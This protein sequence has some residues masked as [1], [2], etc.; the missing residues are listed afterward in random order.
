MGDVLAFPGDRARR[1]AAPPVPSVGLAWSGR[2]KSHAVMPGAHHV[3]LCGVEVN[4]RTVTG[5]LTFDPAHDD[6]CGNCVTRLRRLRDA[7]HR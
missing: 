7:A 4:P 2:G 3:G 5:R 6:S 1:P